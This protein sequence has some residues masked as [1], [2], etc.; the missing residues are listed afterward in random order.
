MCDSLD[1]DERTGRQAC[2]L[3]RRTRRGSIADV[4][5]VDLVHGGEVP[6]ILKEDARLDEV[7]ERA[8]CRLEDRGQVLERAVGLDR[9]VSLDGG[10]T[11]LQTELTRD[12]PL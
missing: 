6:E 4:S 7:R 8:A 12:E 3:E 9:D 1:L 2:D 5:R 11:W 10:V